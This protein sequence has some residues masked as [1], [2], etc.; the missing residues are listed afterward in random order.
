MK[1]TRRKNVKDLTKNR[2]FEFH[3]N[4]QKSSTHCFEKNKKL[5]LFDLQMF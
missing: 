5:D 2:T 4:K 1:K 3:K